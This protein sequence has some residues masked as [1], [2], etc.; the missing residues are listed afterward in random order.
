MGVTTN[1]TLLIMRTGCVYIF[2][3]SIYCHNPNSGYHHFSL[4]LLHSSRNCSLSS[5]LNEVWFSQTVFHS[6]DGVILLKCKSD[7]S[8]YSPSLPQMSSFPSLLFY[9]YYFLILKNCLAMLCS[10]WDLRSQTR[11]RTCS[12]CI[13]SVEC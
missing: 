9:H 2:S 3:V 13:G 11:D 4:R 12:L 5:L 8:I 1:F 6:V 7:H 10:V